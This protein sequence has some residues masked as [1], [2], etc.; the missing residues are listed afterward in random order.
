MQIGFRGHVLLFTV[1]A[2]A[3]AWLAF[4]PQAEAALTLSSNVTQ[5]TTVNVNKGQNKFFQIQMSGSAPV[6]N[7]VVMNLTS[8]SG[9]VNPS[10]FTPTFTPGS[11]TIPANGT[12]NAFFVL[13]INPNVAPGTYTLS[14]N[15]YNDTAGSSKN[16]LT[17]IISWTVAVGDFSLAIQPST[18][19]VR[20]GSSS[21]VTVYVNSVSG[22]TGTV[23]LSMIN[24]PSG[25]S[26]TF[27]PTT[28]T[29]NPGQA[30]ALSTLTFQASFSAQTGSFTSSIV[31]NYADVVIHTL[32]V[33]I[34]VQSIP[35]LVVTITANP[36]PAVV[37][38]ISTISV[39]VTSDGVPIQDASLT[40][41]TTGGAL[42]AT[43]GSTD[44]SGQ[45]LTTFNSTV[46]GQVTISATA[47]KPNYVTG[48][49]SLSLTVAGNFQVSVSPVDV[50]MTLGSTRAFQI[51]IQSIEGFNSAVVLA[52]APS[53]SGMTATITPQ[54]VTPPPNGVVTA[55]L[56]ISL[57]L[58]ATPGT[59]DL[60]ITGTRSPLVKTASLRL[61]IP[62][63]DFDVVV[64]P[65]SLTIAQGK[66]GFYNLSITSRG[67]FTGFMD[68]RAVGI[69]EDVEFT[70]VPNSINLE[71]GATRTI[72]LSVKASEQTKAGTFLF[73]IEANSQGVIKRSAQ[74]VLVI[75][76]LLTITI[77]TTPRVSA[78]VVDNI[79]VPFTD[80]PKQYKW[81]KGETH[82]IGVPA[83]IVE[84]NPG[85]RYVFTK[86]IDGSTSL[87]RAVVINDPASFKAEFKTQFFLTVRTSIPDGP[88]PSMGAGWYDNGTQAKIS[89]PN[90]IN[91]SSDR[92]YDFR[93]WTGNLTD[94]KANTT[95]LTDKPKTVISSYMLQFF[96]K[97]ATNPE[98]LSEVVNGNV[99]HDSGITINF[100]TTRRVQDH[101]FRFW[102][103]DGKRVTGLPAS[104]KIDKPMLV[105]ANYI[106]LPKVGISWANTTASK[107]EFQGESSYTWLKITNTKDRAGEVRLDVRSNFE[108]IDVNPKTLVLNFEA[109]QSFLLGFE[110]KFLKDGT[111]VIEAKINE[112]AG[113]PDSISVSL[114][115]FPR[116][117]RDNLRAVGKAISVE[118]LPVLNDLMNPTPEVKALA[119]RILAASNLQP[120]ASTVDK[121]KA[122][123]KFVNQHYEPSVGT[124]PPNIAKITSDLNLS[125]GALSTLKISGDDRVAQVFFGGLLRSLSMQVRPVI[126]TMEM[127]PTTE[128][129]YATLHSWIEF[130]VDRDW[131][132]ADPTEAVLDLASINFP[133]NIASLAKDSKLFYEL[134]P[135]W[136]GPIAVVTYE[137]KAV[138]VTD[139]Y[140]LSAYANLEG[141]V[142][143]TRG[144]ASIT[145]RD[146]SGKEFA[147]GV[148]YAVVWM[149]IEPQATEIRAMRPQGQVVLLSPNV[150]ISKFPIFVSGP[151]RSDYMFL[152]ME[153]SSVFPIVDSMAG[154]FLE[155][156]INEHTVQTR[157]DGRLQAG[158]VEHV[159][160]ADKSSVDV[161]SNST[162]TAAA[163]STD[164]RAVRLTLVGREGTA[165][166]LNVSVPMN[167]L[168]DQL[169]ST[170]EKI[171]V[172][173][174]NKFANP[175]INVLANRVIVSLTYSHSTRNIVVYLKTFE[176]S[177]DTRDP[178]GLRIYDAELTM[179]GPV[180]HEIKESSTPVFKPL[181]PGQYQFTIRYR[182]E[183]QVITQAITDRDVYLRINLLR[184][185]T[186]I[187]GF[188]AG[189]II[190]VAIIAIITQLVLSRVFQ[191]KITSS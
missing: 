64:I 74:A 165:G 55:T 94:A 83:Q 25:V 180:T 68:I 59:I 10:S 52:I 169:G 105:T 47:S 92:R 35:A 34:V 116:Q 178:L 189:V 139:R 79:Q 80:L 111:G 155:R 191:R 152:T 108:G 187:A 151:K 15:G 168:T 51:T 133:P 124:N 86:W 49:V 32:E 60:T 3:I 56:S 57:D 33:P 173:R 132:F 76:P 190:A 29:L 122:I 4:M 157:R 70:L 12:V 8:V 41:S 166:I 84:G 11:V 103:A 58:T 113:A 167:L 28:V 172:L 182:G 137:S 1:V 36:N 140:K 53:I 75:L 69:P 171:V 156:G 144:D 39:R 154:S 158:Q 135:R 95:V 82:T 170:I 90:R 186:T 175:E 150:L 85:I 6:G 46:P 48:S 99:W 66:Q 22:F 141:N 24:L 119:E 160:Y 112:T 98:G 23:S 7:R 174:D 142:I 120:D 143:Y 42:G 131:V 73:L 123:L 63:R 71:A 102:I 176:V 40:L 145:V 109:G 97:A 163:S 30:Y 134:S 13:K 9:G 129:P 106:L 20:Q 117:S 2:I 19:T 115:I 50:I 147:Q 161:T 91:I 162:I 43:S 16:I 78:V 14:A 183:K 159:N 31:G 101:S 153:V 26:G 146:D 185:D 93:G 130:K 65:P 179:D 184:S 27:N 44:A 21:A 67:G 45:F 88:L 125:G 87:L 110:L 118:V 114:K 188:A 37:S 104:I 128:T 177:F 17:N 62:V 136:G 72:L 121:A 54:V 149:P 148:P 126:G 38:K 181:I 96:V 77:D 81:V 61:N 89:T 107:T 5:V 138:D 127:S 100:T 18:A 164:V